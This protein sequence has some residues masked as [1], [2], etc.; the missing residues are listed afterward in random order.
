MK[1]ADTVFQRAQ[2]RFDTLPPHEQD[3]WDDMQ[4]K[5][6]RAVATEYLKHQ[7]VMLIGDPSLVEYAIDQACG[8]IA[9]VWVPL[10]EGEGKPKRGR[11]QVDHN[12]RIIYAA[13]F[14][15]FFT[16]GSSTSAAAKQAAQ[17]LGE[18]ATKDR[19]EKNLKAWLH[20]ASAAV[21]ARGGCPKLRR[22]LWDTL[23]VVADELRIIA[24]DLEQERA[25]EAARRKS[26]RHI[27]FIGEAA[28][29][30]LPSPK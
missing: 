8:E 1:P 3:A 17:F 6:L 22:F 14:S 28:P 7:G 18:P 15:I 2:R 26:S 29:R 25:A 27:S 10:L 16:E 4:A 11:P 13:A 30:S 19:V 20:K 23:F 12:T 21:R 24:T 9:P 5:V